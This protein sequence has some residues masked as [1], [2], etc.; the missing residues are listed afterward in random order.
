[1]GTIKYVK[2]NFIVDDVNDIGKLHSSFFGKIEK[3]VL[4]LQPEEVLYLIDI[5]KF[6][7]VD[8]HDN[9]LGFNDVVKMFV[10]KNPKIFAFYNAFRDWRDRGLFITRPKKGI[11]LNRRIS[12]DYPSEKLQLP[13]IKSKAYFYPFDMISVSEDLSSLRK[14]FEEF[15]IG[16]LGV[17]KRHEKGSLIKFDIFETLFLVKH[18]DIK[19]FSIEDEEELDFSTILNIVS[20]VR[21][22]IKALYEVYEDWRL[23]GFVIKTGYKFGSHFR[24]YFPGVSPVRK[25]RWIH[26]KHVLHVFPK[27]ERLL[28]SEWAR[29]IRVAHSVRKTFVLG[30]PEMK[31]DDFEDVE[32]DFVAYHREGG[33]VITPTTGDPSF[34]VLTLS[35]DE[36][37]GGAELASAL[38]EAEKMGLDLLLAVTDRETDVTYYLTKK[39]NLPKSKYEYYEIE[40]FQP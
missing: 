21:K 30:I 18:T 25:D 26:S 23:K 10:N 33:K 11:K 12:V 15:W 31:K 13:K 9:T 34:V 22:D 19:F 20:K 7:C 29:V 5:R 27:Y 24:I 4:T 38:K 8:E 36:T 2:G 40:W 32:L 37:I 14:L 16:Q 39:I 1:M 28:I 6:D 17:Y 35:E 3:G